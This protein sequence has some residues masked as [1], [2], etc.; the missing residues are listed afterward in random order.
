MRTIHDGR[1]TA[2]GAAQEFWHTVKPGIVSESLAYA[3][4]HTRAG[5]VECRTHRDGVRF[6]FALSYESRRDRQ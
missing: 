1:P 3:A 2:V 6:F 4:A 5:T